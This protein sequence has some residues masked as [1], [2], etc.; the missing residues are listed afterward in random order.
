MSTKGHH[1]KLRMD[2]RDKVAGWKAQGVSNSECGRRLGRPVSTIGRELKR[3]SE[4][5]VYAAIHAQGKA[6][7][8]AEKSAHSKHPLKNAEVYA[9][10]TEH[11]R[12]G[13]S[14]EQIA[15]RMA[16]EHPNDPTWRITDETIYRWVYAPQQADQR[17]WEYLRRKQ[18]KRRKRNGRSVRRSRISDRISI[19]ERPAVVNA[20]QEV[21]HWEGDTVEGKGHRDGVHTEVERLSRFLVARKVSAITSQ[22]TIAAQHQI[23]AELPACLRRSTTLDNGR[24]NHLHAQLRELGMQTYFADPYSSWQRG[25]NENGNWHL[26]YYFPKGTDFAAVPDDELQDVVDEI[27]HR[28]RK[29]LGFATACETLARLAQNQQGVA[30][31]S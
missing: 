17:W 30:I 19:R 6:W 14:P 10:V 22:A 1:Q 31:D 25:T 26:R 24:E 18:T 16:L 21:G 28:P 4:Q 27:N 5:G 8:R 13:W 15:G 12:D 7:E 11:L 9:Y 23:F 3:N 2:E 20:R 29:I